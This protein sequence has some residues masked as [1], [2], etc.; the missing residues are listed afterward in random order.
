MHKLYLYDVTPESQKQLQDGLTTAGELK[1]INESLSPA[2]AAPDA[3]VV[4]VFVSSPVTAEIMSAMPS[5]KLI[6]CRSTGIDN[7]DLAAAKSRGIAVASV[8]TY[9][10]HTVAEYTFALLLSLTRKLPQAMSALEHGHTDHPALEGSDLAGKTLG[11]IGTGKIGRNVAVIAKAFGMNITAYD[12]F[13]NTEAAA[14]IGFTYAALDDVIRTADVITLHVPLTPDTRHLISR[15]RLALAKPSAIIVNTARGEVVD[16]KALVEALAE[17]RLSGAALDVFEGEKLSDTQEELMQL[18]AAAV[19]QMVLEQHLE[20]GI[21]K[22][23]PNVILTNHNAFNTAEAVGRIN[24][25]TI[26]NITSY[27][28]NKPQNLV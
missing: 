16:T 21:L 22:N 15:E 13:P 19:D 3:T 14:S 25:T 6:A 20:L 2:T 28:A 9:G 27:I 5:L 23:M 12:P 18:R 4:S 7:V 17:H 26:A 1:L 10:D 11:L 8:P 24:D